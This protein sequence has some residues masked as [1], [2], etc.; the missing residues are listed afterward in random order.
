MWPS[1]HSFFSRSQYREVTASRNRADEPVDDSRQTGCV[2]TFPTTH[3]IVSFMREPL[4]RAGAAVGT[5][6]IRVRARPVRLRLLAV[7][8]S[9]TPC[10]VFRCG[11][12]AAGSDCRRRAEPAER[13]VLLASCGQ[14]RHPTG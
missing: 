1:A 8:A 11:A 5:G 2:A 7:I 12:I 6:R 10:G 9:A 3:T 4:L 13:C 14:L